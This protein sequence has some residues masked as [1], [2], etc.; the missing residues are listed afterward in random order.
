MLAIYA[1]L[2]NSQV[3]AVFVLNVQSVWFHSAQARANVNF[4]QLEVQ[5]QHQAHQAVHHVLLAN[6]QSLAQLVFHV[7]PVQFLVQVPLNAA[8]VHVVMKSLLVYVHFVNLENFRM[9]VVFVLIAPL[10]ML[11]SVK[12]LV[13]VL[14]A[15]LELKLL[16]LAHLLVLLANLDNFHQ[17]APLVLHALKVLFRVQEPV[18]AHLVRVVS[19]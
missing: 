12:A 14:V 10:V 1:L 7:L 3:E 2:V 5:Q 16:D 13:V 9:K 19:R 18:S 8:L 6:F 15:H 4:V 17:M 11:H